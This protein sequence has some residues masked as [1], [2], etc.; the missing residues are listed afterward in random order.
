MHIISLTA[1]PCTWWHCVPTVI[2]V[3]SG[4]LAAS[5]THLALSEPC[6]IAFT[7]NQM[8][9]WWASE[10][11]AGE[12]CERCNPPGIWKDPA[13]S[14]ICSWPQ[15][16]WIP[17]WFPPTPVMFISKPLLKLVF[18]LCTSSLLPSPYC[19][20]CA[21]PGSACWPSSRFTFQHVLLYLF[22]VLIKSWIIFWLVLYLIF[23]IGKGFQK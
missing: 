3:S 2:Q 16:N 10:I 19:L 6:L 15:T 8:G 14:D 5:S 1:R 23:P 21:P 18:C 12:Y 11:G 7:P 9:A 22:I 13:Q 20:P 4:S 17:C